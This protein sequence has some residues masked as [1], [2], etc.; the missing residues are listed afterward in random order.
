MVQWLVDPERALSGPDMAD[1]LC[2]ILGNA[3]PAEQTRPPT[4]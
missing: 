4:T 1:A 3:R 2:A